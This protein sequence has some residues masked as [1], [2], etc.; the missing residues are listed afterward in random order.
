MEEASQ[1][2]HQVVPV[3]AVD[4]KVIIIIMI[5]IITV[6]MIIIITY[7]TCGKCLLYNWFDCI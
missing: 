6:I 7:L 5:I 4:D 3:Q 2:H 1:W